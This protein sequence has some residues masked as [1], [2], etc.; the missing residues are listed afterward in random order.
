MLIDAHC[1]A[2]ALS[3]EA[4][5]QLEDSAHQRLLVVSGSAYPEDWPILRQ[6]R[7]RYDWLRCGAGIHPWY[8]RRN[9]A[10]LSDESLLHS[11]DAMLTAEG[12]TCWA[13]INEIGLDRSTAQDRLMMPRQR[14]LFREQLRL[15]HKHDLPI[16]VHS[17]NAYLLT[18]TELGE[19][20]VPR[21]GGLL[22]GYWGSKEMLQRFL[23]LG[24]YVSL[25]ATQILRASGAWDGGAVGAGEGAVG[26]GE[27]AVR[28][29]DKVR[30]LWAQIPE[31][32]RI[33][34]TDSPGR[35]PLTSPVS[36]TQVASGIA[37]LS[38]EDPV[39]LCTTCNRN[40]SRLFGL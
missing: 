34:E 35:F 20:G 13:S 37:S 21:R 1:H 17:V 18:L 15:A 31:T 2:A 14:A 7:Q 29:R 24:L 33:L 23:G 32:R 38:G 40:A 16:V 39:G 11:L 36:L 10:T 12:G 3:P 19:M 26:T 28:M 9:T 22:H 27:G 30:E 8:C 25:S 4:L 5:A 6:L